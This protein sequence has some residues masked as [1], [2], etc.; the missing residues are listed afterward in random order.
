MCFRAEG[1]G[2]GKPSC[3]GEFW[4]SS[5]LNDGW[6]EM[7]HA[8]SNNTQRKGEGVLKSPE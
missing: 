8:G 7:E 4:K 3:R 5:W 6:Q 2:G 1:P